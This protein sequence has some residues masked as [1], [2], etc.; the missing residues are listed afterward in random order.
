M[1]LWIRAEFWSISF[2][3]SCIGYAFWSA[4][5]SVN[6]NFCS[7]LNVTMPQADVND[8]S[9]DRIQCSEG[10]LGSSLPIVNF[11]FYALDI[12]YTEVLRYHFSILAWD[13]VFWNFRTRDAK[14]FKNGFIGQNII[15][16]FG[17]ELLWCFKMNF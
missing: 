1:F 15:F 9:V 3:S 6:A 10:F 13:S 4:L 17:S 2:K 12:S 14:I 8:G 5:Q 7:W 11:F 16:S